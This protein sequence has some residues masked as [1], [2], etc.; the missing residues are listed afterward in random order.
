MARINKFYLDQL[1]NYH[2][3]LNGTIQ[4]LIYSHAQFDML[5]NSEYYKL[6]SMIYEN[7]VSNLNYLANIDPILDVLGFPV[8]NRNIRNSIE[9]YYD[10]YNLCSDQDYLSLLK[11]Y[12]SCEI[13]ADRD[14]EIVNRKYHKYKPRSRY[15]TIKI[16]ANIAKYEYHL[17]EEI[18]ELLKG[19]SI[20]TNAYVHS[21]VFIRADIHKKTG[22]LMELVKTDCLI[23]CYA[24]ELMQEYINHVYHSSYHFSPYIEYQKIMFYLSQTPLFL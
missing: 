16:K 24:Y 18:Y 22:K 7:F 8:T 5:K 2:V 19:I 15:L 17:N 9:V 21:D 20:H 4:S 10:L 14:R 1:Y 23:L 6:F 13:P 12:S 3:T 11:V